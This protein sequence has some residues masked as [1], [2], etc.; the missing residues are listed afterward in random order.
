MK[1]TLFIQFL[2]AIIPVCVFAQQNTTACGGEAAG[3]G[4]TVSFAIGQID[5]LAPESP[6]GTVYQGVEQPIELFEDGSIPAADLLISNYV[7]PNNDGQN[8]TWKINNPELVKDFSLLI[9]DQWGNVVYQK[10]GNYLNEW[11]GTQ[12][13]NNLS[14]GVYYYTFSSGGAVKF[15]GSITLIK[16]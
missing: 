8:D 15:R 1:R 9:T 7:S 16:N 10:A 11:D 2:L 14:D 12:N 3:T 4:G 13:G 5:Y 6:A